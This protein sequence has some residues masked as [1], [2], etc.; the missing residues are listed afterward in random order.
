MDGILTDAAVSSAWSQ[1]IKRFHIRDG[2]GLAMLR[3]EGIKVGW[4]SKRPSSATTRRA[5]EL[6]IDFLEQD[7][8]SKVAAVENILASTGIKWEE[9]CYMGDDIVDLGV[10][11]R[12]GVAATVADATAEAKAAAHYITRA[13]GG[14]GGVREMVELILKAKKRWKGIVAEESA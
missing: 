9:V 3:K 5:E 2:L 10:L 8:G 6:K 13:A 14:H 4:V 7:K 11:K 1:E 12:A